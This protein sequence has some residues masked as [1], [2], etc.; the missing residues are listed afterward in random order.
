MVL[1]NL[2]KN[3]GLYVAKIKI[4]ASI[5]GGTWKVSHIFAR[6]GLGHDTY[7]YEDDLPEITFQVEPSDINIEL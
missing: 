2:M 5:E 7:Y 4:P 1:Q 3:S 6:D